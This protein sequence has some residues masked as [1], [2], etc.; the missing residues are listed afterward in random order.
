ME[1]KGS[2]T[3]ETRIGDAVDGGVEGEGQLNVRT[4]A[5]KLDH[6]INAFLNESR[7]EGQT[8]KYLRVCKFVGVGDLGTAVYK[9]VNLSKVQVKKLLADAQIS[10]WLD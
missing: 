10:E 3:N 7:I 5:I 9:S 1:N 2:K 4:P 6:G 8:D